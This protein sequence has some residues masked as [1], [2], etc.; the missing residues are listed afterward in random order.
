MVVL[1]NKS[2]S[3]GRLGINLLLRS[4]DFLAP[5]RSSIPEARPNGLPRHSP[6]LNAFAAPGDLTGDMTDGGDHE[7]PGHRQS[8]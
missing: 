7:D 1:L 2:R 8:A 5:N 4:C 6:S 3:G